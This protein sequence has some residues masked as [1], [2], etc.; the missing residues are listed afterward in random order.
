MLRYLT[1]KLRKSLDSS[2]HKYSVLLS[3][4]VRKAFDSVN[5]GLL[6][7]KLTNLYNFS[8]SS[9]K[10]L[11]SYLTDRFQCTKILNSISPP[12]RIT[13]GVPQGSILGPMLF[14]LMVNDLLQAHPY[15]ISYADD[16]SLIYSSDSLPKT[17][18]G[19]DNIFKQVSLWYEENGF[20]INLKKSTCLLL[21]NR[22]SVSRLSTITLSNMLTPIQDHISL[23]GVTLDSRLNFQPY[24]LTA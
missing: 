20:E 18:S 5:H 17:V 21:R 22:P 16:T 3:L 10:L 13:K 1:D 14:I 12:A 2:A 23:L 11:S 24:K 15:T 7:T 19:L 6:L 8:K 4:D 9:I